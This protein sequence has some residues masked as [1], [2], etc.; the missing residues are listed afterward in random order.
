[1][2]A[3]LAAA[4]DTALPTRFRSF[5]VNALP[6]VEG[7]TVAL[8]RD[9]AADANESLAAS[10]LEHLWPQHLT[11]VDYFELLPTRM[12]WTYRPTLETRL[13]TVGEEHLNDALDWSAQTLQDRNAKSLIATALLGRCIRLIGQHEQNS[14]SRVQRAGQALVALADHPEMSDAVESRPAL[15]YLR[16]SLHAAPSLRR[17]IA[18]YVLCHGSQDTVMELTFAGPQ[19]GMFP[20]E[21]LLYWAQHWTDLPVNARRAAHPLFD[22]RPRPGGGGLQAA[23]EAARQ[24]DAEL[25][26]AT[27]WWDAP[28]PEWRLRRQQQEEEQRRDDTFDEGQFA[29]ALASVHAAGPDRVR[30]AWSTVIAHLYRTHDGQHVEQTSHL[31]AVAAAPSRPPIGTILGEKLAAAAG[32]VLI[33][34]PVWEARHVTRWGTDWFHVPELAALPLMADEQATALA[35]DIDRWTGWALALATMTTPEQD[36][37]LHQFLFAQCVRRAGTPFQAA[38]AACLDRLETFRLTDL[39]RRL[40]DLAADEAVGTVRAWAAA[41][42]R[43]DAAWEAVVVK[44]ASLG[45]GPARDLV[46]DAVTAVPSPVTPAA[47]CARWISAAQSVMREPDLR[48]SWS[49]IR[50]AFGDPQMCRE[51]I[52]RLVQDVSWPAGVARLDEADLADLYIRLCRRE[53]LK[54]PLPEREPGVAYRITLQEELHRFAQTLLRMLADKGTYQAADELSRLSASAV[55]PD[56]HRPY[57]RDL[58][59]RTARQAARR[60]SRPLPIQQLSKLAT[61]HSLRVVTD[62]AQLLSVVMETL[63]RVQEA[64]SGPNG[65]AILLWNREAAGRSAMWPMW[66]EDFSDLVMGLLKIHL[67]GQRTI[68]NREV[69]V[70]R[71]GLGGGRTDIHIQTA[72]P[73]QGTEP[74]TVVVEAKG[75]WNRELPTALD[76]QLVAR[77]LRRPHTAGI[78]LVGFFDCDLWQSPKRRPCSPQHTRQQIERDQQHRAAQHDVHVRAKVLDCRPPGIQID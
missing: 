52:D 10:A 48:K 32:H 49:H 51:V 75:C 30:A 46:R 14:D 70:D 4:E 35:A 68:V 27:A 37:E 12:P 78:F 22:R 64:L 56:S 1:M 53:E 38:L 5:A 72:D 13:D 43:S 71:P 34:A 24:A 26:E 73:S 54:E 41:S 42:G 9:L 39:V 61:D 16:E 7:D 76:D 44:L 17:R 66:E 20:E 62:E 77:Y 57:A 3:L 40:H 58:A 28:P 63:D 6:E 36:K 21:D 55:I 69:Q 60:Q 11:L 31:D 50:A 8:L 33:T 59:H 45:D 19:V 18:E 15:E 29:A 47:D 25:R 74:L 67:A 2:P 65:M 23:V